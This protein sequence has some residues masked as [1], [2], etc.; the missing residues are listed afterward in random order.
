MTPTSLMKGPL[1]ANFWELVQFKHHT[2][3]S[4]GLCIFLVLA[5]SCSC[6][7]THLQLI[8]VGLVVRRPNLTNLFPLHVQIPHLAL[9][10]AK[11]H[12]VA[13][14]QDAEH[15]L[16]HNF[17]L[18]RL[19]L[20]LSDNGLLLDDGRARS[21]HLDLRSRGLRRGRSRRAW[22][23]RGMGVIRGRVTG[24][25]GKTVGGHLCVAIIPLGKLPS[26]HREE[27]NALLDSE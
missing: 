12:W 10:I 19:Y 8:F 14:P 7:L 20:G 21:L 16:L 23:G 22:L 4:L 13:A 26:R 27:V 24:T 2:L 6:H 3:C 11:H 17:S 9:V 18:L 5:Y 1:E 15:T 25:R